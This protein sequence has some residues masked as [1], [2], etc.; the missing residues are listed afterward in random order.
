M[1]QKYHNSEKF[2]AN[3][4]ATNEIDLFIRTTIKLNGP[5][6]HIAFLSSKESYYDMSIYTLD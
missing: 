6:E 5:K 4:M 1:Y 3:A 2:I